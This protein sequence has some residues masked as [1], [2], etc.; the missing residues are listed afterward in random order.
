MLNKITTLLLITVLSLAA[1]FLIRSL[2]HKEG[3]WEFVGYQYKWNK[4]YVDNSGL[5][6]EKDC[7]NYGNEWL[8]KQLSADVLFT[9]SNL[10]NCQN[11]GYGNRMMVCDKVCE[12][13]KNGLI[14]CRK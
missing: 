11:L 12:Y 14:R 5:K 9:C 3:N 4:D 10:N 2:V 1:A 8:S 13:G 6:S 7:I